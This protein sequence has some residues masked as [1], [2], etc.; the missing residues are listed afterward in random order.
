MTNII[1]YDDT[2]IVDEEG[3]AEEHMV[4]VDRLKESLFVGQAGF[5]K[6]GQY[7]TEIRE[8]ETYK[9]EDANHEHTWK[10]F[11]SRPDLPLNGAT[12]EGRVRTSQKLMTVWKNIASVPEV[13]EGLLSRIGYTKLAIV[14]GVLSRD[15]NAELNDWLCKAEQLTTTDLQ[16]EASDGGK[17]LAEVQDCEHDNYERIDRWKCSDCKKVMAHEPGQEDKK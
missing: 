10:D 12:P 11:C 5:I 1:P 6:A 8:K 15:P 14:A 3:L 4:L 7:L 9:Y 2:P 17:T 13:D 16:A